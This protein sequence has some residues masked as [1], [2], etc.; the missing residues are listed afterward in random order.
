MS[1]DRW[2]PCALA[3]LAGC[4]FVV[5]V[6][7]PGLLSPDSVWQLHQAMLHQYSDQHPP[8]MAWVWSGLLAVVPGPTGML[9]LQNV[10]FW[11]ADALIWAALGPAQ[12]AWVGVLASGLFPPIFALLGIVWKDV[13]MASA[14]LLAIALLIVQS[15]RRL[16]PWALVLAL[17]LLVYAAAVRSNGLLAV[18]PILWLWL[19]SLGGLHGRRRLVAAA[20]LSLAVGICSWTLNRT[21]TSVEDH[22][23]QYFEVHDLIGLSLD[24][25]TSLFPA[26]YWESRAQLS[27]DEMAAGYNPL[28]PSSSFWHPENGPHFEI[29]SNPKGA[30][31]SER[32]KVLRSAWIAALL[33]YPGNII[34]DRW[35]LMTHVFGMRKAYDCYDYITE[36]QPN[37]M[38]VALKWPAVHAAVLKRFEIFRHGLLYRGWIFLLV[39][40]GSVVFA[41]RSRSGFVRGATLS[42]ALSGVGS[43]LVYPVLGASC[44]FRYLWWLLISAMLC[45][46]LAIMD[47]ESGNA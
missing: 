16:A 29:L 39:L 33:R 3:A 25:R 30:Q 5:W 43:V 12:L 10:L 4:A 45:L 47:R 20:G 11:G 7:A 22:I 13:Q 23:G 42:I 24:A 31:P 41:R 17:T 15:R 26:G 36:M 32:L 44:D 8:V 18:A 38:G 1:R 35:S 46:F 14:L 34:R 40:T 6:N 28:E 21:L 2:L 9:I 27:L 37:D 19:G